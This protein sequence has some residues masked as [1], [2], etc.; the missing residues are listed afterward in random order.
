[1]VA[2]MWKG[3]V[4]APDADEV[5]RHLREVALARYEAETGCVSTT[6]LTRPLAGG[7]ELVSL[8]VWTSEAS[9]PA[10][11]AEDHQLLVAR[12]TVA[13]VWE[14]AEAPQAVARAA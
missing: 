1:M 10:G 2:R 3:W 13:D 8:T 6:V 14:V 7:V 9:V 4:G 5:A 11:V 12:Q